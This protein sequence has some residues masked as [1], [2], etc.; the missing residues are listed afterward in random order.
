MELLQWAIPDFYS[1][2]IGLNPATNNIRDMWYL[3]VFNTEKFVKQEQKGVKYYPMSNI[4]LCKA[5]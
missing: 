5:H 3:T 2:Q 4:T 1:L